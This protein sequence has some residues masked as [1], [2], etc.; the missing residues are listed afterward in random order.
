MRGDDLSG[1]DFERG[2]Q[3]RGAVAL[4]VVA[5]AGQS[6]SVW[7]LQITLRALQRL[8][9]RLFVD[10]QDNGLCRR[11]NV[12]ADNIGGFGRKLRIVALA[13]GFASR[14]GDLVAAQE[15]PDI[16]NVNIAQRRG[17][18]RS[19]PAREP[20]WCRLVQ[21][22][23]NPPVGR[24]RIDRL[25]AG[26]RLVLQALETLIGKAV[27][28]EADDPWLDAYLLGDRARAAAFRRQQNNPRPLQ[29][30]LQ[31]ARRAT[32]RF[33][34]LALLPR[35]ADFSCFGNHPYLESRLTFHG[36]RVLCYALC[37]LHW[38]VRHDDL[39]AATKLVL[40]ASPEDLRRQDTDAWWRERRTKLE[41]VDAQFCS[42]DS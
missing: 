34:L 24:L 1:G 17:Q 28:P 16:L 41:S 6:A 8:N 5:L 39:A 36:K 30:T 19:R 37:R 29:I 11:S 2:K 14:K 9:R 21:Q 38:L 18:Q 4:I 3:R 33:Q 31:C 40:A 7:Q 20:L 26:A 35:N 23:Q 10:A 25:F 27:T 13:P 32:T 22:S 15:S 42:S 12:E